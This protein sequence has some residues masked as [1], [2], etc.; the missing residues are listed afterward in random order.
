MDEDLL[1]FCAV[2]A[3]F[4]S[5][6]LL[7]VF[8]ITSCIAYSRTKAWDKKR[9]QRITTLESEPLVAVTTTTSSADAADPDLDLDYDTEDEAEQTQRKAQEEADRSLSFWQMYR[10]N[11]ASVWR[12]KGREEL[13]RE[14]ERA[15]RRERRK[16]AREVVR[17]L[18]RRERMGRGVGEGL[19][20]YKV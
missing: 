10:R 8:S 9:N 1:A 15:E 12:G 7:V 4:L 20:P 2:M 17:L 16:I 11:F 3:V 13:V 14:K 6:P 19:P 18:E 5:A